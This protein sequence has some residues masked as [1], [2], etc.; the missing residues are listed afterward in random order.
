MNVDWEDIARKADE[1]PSALLAGFFARADE[2]E[3]VF[4]AVAF[5]GRSAWMFDWAGSSLQVIGMLRVAEA[6]L[7]QAAKEPD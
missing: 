2:I 7:S 1:S 4:V 5:K 3:T 6:D